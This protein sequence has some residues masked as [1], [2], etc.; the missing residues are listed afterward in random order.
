MANKK[1]IMSVTAG[2]AI[3]S[4]MVGADQVEAASHKVQSGDSL[5][6]IAQKH[7]TTVTNLKK[8]NN[9]TSDLI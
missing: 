5:W 6:T 2:A 9:L 8:I 4:A 3:A 1:V 7:N